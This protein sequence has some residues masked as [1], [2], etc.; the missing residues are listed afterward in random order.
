MTRWQSLKA[1]LAANAPLTALVGTRIYPLVAPAPDSQPLIIQKWSVACDYTLSSV[2]AVSASLEIRSWAPDLE[3]AQQIADA[4]H[5]ILSPAGD[6]GGFRGLLGGTGGID[7]VQCIWAA[8]GA[9]EEANVV[10]IAEGKYAF[11]VL[12]PYDLIYNL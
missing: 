4:V 6:A 9:R 7:V 10:T 2:G 1:A 8:D 11:E 3:L 12:S 5:A